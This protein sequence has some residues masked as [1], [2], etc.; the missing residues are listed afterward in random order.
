MAQHSVPPPPF[1]PSRGSVMTGAPSM[2]S[3]QQTGTPSVS[4]LSSM[5]SNQP[6][7]NGH[8]SYFAA[9]R[10]PSIISSPSP[11]PPSTVGFPRPIAE[12]R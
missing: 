10:T 12:G 8:N 2:L 1:D 7:V 3:P 4:E 9:P 6:L 11:G 5:S